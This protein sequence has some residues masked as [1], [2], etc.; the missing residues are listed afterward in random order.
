MVVSDSLVN[1][2]HTTNK[3]FAIYEKENGFAQYVV[4][5]LVMRLLSSASM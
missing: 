4:M 1:F 2:C 5:L 3:N